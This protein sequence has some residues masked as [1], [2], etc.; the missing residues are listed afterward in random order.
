MDEPRQQIA[1]FGSWRDS[2]AQEHVKD[3]GSL[4]KVWSNKNNK[5]AFENACK[6]LGREIARNKH[7]LLVASDS[8]STVD[9]HIV[10]GII[11]GRASID[12]NFRPIHVIRSRAPRSSHSDNDC[13]TI[14]HQKF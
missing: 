5:E 4:D 6:E 11:E 14:L 9:Y 3:V 10:H 8:P 2:K 13:S 1:V 7:K 12:P